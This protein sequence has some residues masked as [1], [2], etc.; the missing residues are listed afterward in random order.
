MAKSRK[1]PVSKRA[2]I[3][4]INR[5]LAPSREMLKAARGERLRQQVGDYYL[6]DIRANAVL[7][8]NVD[9]VEMARGLGVLM[10]WEEL[11]SG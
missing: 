3:Q 5:K 10:G 2:V 8:H 11:R 6:I 1:I 9:I 4:R 7:R